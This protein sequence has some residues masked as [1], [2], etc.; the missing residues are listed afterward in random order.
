MRCTIHGSEEL[1][2]QMTISSWTVLHDESVI[3]RGNE[4]EEKG[5]RESKIREPQATDLNSE[6]E[7]TSPRM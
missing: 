5:K 2:L 6:K 1:G 3:T 4:V 7:A